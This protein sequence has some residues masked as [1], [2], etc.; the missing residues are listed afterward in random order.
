M[1]IMRRF[2]RFPLYIVLILWS[3]ICLYPLVWM[4]STSLKTMPEVTEDPA[5]L[6]PET[7]HWAN[8]LETWTKGNFGTYFKNSLIITGAVLLLVLW[9]TSMTAFAITRTDFPGKRLILYALVVTLFIP[10]EATLVPVFHIAKSLHLLNSLAGII[11]A[12]V[13]GSQVVSIYLIQAYFRTIPLDLD[14]AAKIDGCNLFQRYWYVVL[15]L[16]RPVLATV[17]ILTF[18]GA[19]NA[20]MLPL[21]F[22]MARPTLRTLPVGL[23]AFQSGFAFSV[24]WPL[25]CA[26]AAIS[27]IPVVVLYVFL[28]RYFVGGI[29]ATGLKE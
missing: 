9:T 1:N 28:Q 3:I 10:A 20:Y 7:P 13:A 22:T 15:P 12:L 11:I 25:L 17:A 24:N 5:A 6:I 4:I 8:Y 27:T 14:D 29:A 16:A 19:W 23:V 21:A 2:T 26:G 18:M